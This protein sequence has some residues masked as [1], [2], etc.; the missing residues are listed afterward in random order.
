MK[1]PILKEKFARI[2]NLLGE[3]IVISNTIEN[4]IL[5]VV[6][7][8]WTSIC[9]DCSTKTDAFPKALY[10]ANVDDTDG[11]IK[12]MSIPEVLSKFRSQYKWSPFAFQPYCDKHG[13]RLSEGHFEFIYAYLEAELL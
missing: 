1:D 13:N 8:Q 2:N 4:L 11:S 12:P 5:I 9:N 10:Y 7:E 6:Y 3:Y